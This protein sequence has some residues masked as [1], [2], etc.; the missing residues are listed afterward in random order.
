MGSLNEKNKN[1]NQRSPKYSR[2]RRKKAKKTIKYDSKTTVIVDGFAISSTRRVSICSYCAKSSG[3]S[4][5]CKENH[6]RY[7]ATS[8][9]HWVSIQNKYKYKVMGR[10]RLKMYIRKCDEDIRKESAAEHMKDY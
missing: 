6:S 4:K 10:Y 9:G 2:H 3:C 5:K 7:L 8:A 1:N